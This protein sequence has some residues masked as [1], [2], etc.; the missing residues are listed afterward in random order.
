ML[1]RLVLEIQ[2]YSLRRSLF[3]NC[4]FF[5]FVVFTLFAH[6]FQR[7][8]YQRGLRKPKQ[9][10]VLTI[11]F[12]DQPIFHSHSLVK[13]KRSVLR[14]FQVSSKKIMTHSSVLPN[15]VHHQNHFLPLPFI[16][17]CAPQ[18]ALLQPLLDSTNELTSQL[19]PLPFFYSSF[20]FSSHHFS[21]LSPL[22]ALTSANFNTLAT[23]S[24]SSCTQRRITRSPTLCHLPTH[25]PLGLPLTTEL[26]KQ[27]FSISLILFA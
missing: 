14:S 20:C 2:N 18:Y 25:L 27:F 6:F 15:P 16:I 11:N 10:F 26:Y 1:L 4:S 12:F 7:L 22:L 3:E 23:L 13:R 8:Q 17:F 21:Y 24:Y 19:L 5:S 9:S